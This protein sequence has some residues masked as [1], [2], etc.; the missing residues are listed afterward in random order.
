MT[1]QTADSKAKKKEQ[2]QANRL[3]KVA[4]SI[5]L[6]HDVNGDAYATVPVKGHGET[7]KVRSRPF[8]RWLAEVFF[9]VTKQVP[10]SQA[11]TDKG[12]QPPTIDK[13]LA[14]LRAAFSRGQR[15]GLLTDNPFAKFKVRNAGRANRGQT[16]S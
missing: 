6:F 9:R 4:N 15:L 7:Y 8:K 16:A 11:M 2:S 1:P 12:R 5:E 14:K 10:N 13:T 3:V